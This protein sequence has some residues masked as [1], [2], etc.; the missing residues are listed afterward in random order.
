LSV[1]V[2]VFLCQDG[3]QPA[4]DRNVSIPRLLQ[5]H[6]A[7]AELRAAALPGAPQTPLKDSAGGDGQEAAATASPRAAGGKAYSKPPG[8]AS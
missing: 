2:Q 4:P 6:L 1:Q 5:E 8:A 7:N 3:D